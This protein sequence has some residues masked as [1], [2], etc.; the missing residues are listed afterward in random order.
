MKLKPED[1]LSPK[2]DLQNWH[3]GLVLHTQEGMLC[4]ASQHYKNVLPDNTNRRSKKKKKYAN[5]Y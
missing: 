5:F 1:Q 2:S 3:D 4:S